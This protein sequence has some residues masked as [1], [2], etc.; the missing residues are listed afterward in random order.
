V[1]SATFLDRDGLL[2]RAAVELGLVGDRLT[3]VAAGREV[4]RTTVL[5]G[6]SSPSP[7]NGVELDARCEDLAEAAELILQLQGNRTLGVLDAALC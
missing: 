1:R 7:T 3:N 4:G 5:V 2:A 6:R